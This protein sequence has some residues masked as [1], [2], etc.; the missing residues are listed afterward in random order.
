MKGDP[1]FVRDRQ[2]QN[3][4]ASSAMPRQ[5]IFA[6]RPAMPAI[7][8]SSSAICAKRNCAL[9]QAFAFCPTARKPSSTTPPPCR[10]GLV[11]RRRP[12]PRPAQPLILRKGRG[13]GGTVATPPRH[14]A[15]GGPESQNSGTASA[16]SAPK[17]PMRNSGSSS[18]AATQ[19]NRSNDAI[20]VLDQLPD[21]T[22]QRYPHSD[23]AGAGVP[24]H[25]PH[26]QDGGGPDAVRQNR[27]VP[28]PGLILRHSGG[29]EQIPE[30]QSNLDTAIGSSDVWMALPTLSSKSRD[31]YKSILALIGRGSPTTR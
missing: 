26:R 18:P 21:Q 4:S 25:Q 1:K 31:L 17:A 7:R 16:S 11:R 5:D 24:N 12:L 10:N 23:L 22:G 29:P 3:R 30:A 27:K 13:I 19:A 14:Q 15:T 6:W 8:N 20:A 28:K 9:K 2:A